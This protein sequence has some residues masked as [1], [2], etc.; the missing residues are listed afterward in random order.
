MKATQVAPGYFFI[1]ING[2]QCQFNLTDKGVCVDRSNHASKFFSYED[3]IGIA[4]KQL[5][6]FPLPEPKP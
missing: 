3:L 4:D 6:L 2:E 5:T 1:V